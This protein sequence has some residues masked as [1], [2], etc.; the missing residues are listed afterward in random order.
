VT[1][2]DGGM[3]ATGDEALAKRLRL[4]RQ[5]AMSV[6]DTVRHHSNE[7]VF[8]EYT[9]PAFNLRM[10]DL[11]AAVGR[12]Q[13]ARLD[14]IVR[15]RRRLADR[16]S[17]ALQDHPVLAPPKE[18]AGRRSNWQSYALGLKSGVQ[19]EI[20]QKLLDRGIAAKRGIM[21]AHQEPAYAGKETWRA[22]GTL[23]V[24]ERL[25]DRTVL[26]PLFHGMTDAEQDTVITAL[27][28]VS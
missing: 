27:R 20:L 13:L 5:H 25:R 26:V 15:E 1:T 10:T 4:L 18:R 7:V 6:P 21:N 28:E 11:Q 3:I 19:V 16:Y 24:S 23:A 22:E 2:G 14:A 9:E 8:E 17:E 12:T